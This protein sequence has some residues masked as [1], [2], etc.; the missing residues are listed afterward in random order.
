[1]LGGNQVL[2]IWIVELMTEND[3]SEGTQ[4]RIY[5]FYL[6]CLRQVILFAILYKSIV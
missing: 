4:G 2:I 3:D 6:D 5:T 1:M